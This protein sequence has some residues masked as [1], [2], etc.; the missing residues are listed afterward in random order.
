MSSHKRF[1]SCLVDESKNTRHTMGYGQ[2]VRVNEKKTFAKNRFLKFYCP[3]H[4]DF[5]SDSIESK[6]DGGGGK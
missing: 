4:P 1:V 5:S 6:S 2:Q 3:I